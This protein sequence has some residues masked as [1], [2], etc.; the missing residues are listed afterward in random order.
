MNSQLK[1]EIPYILL[2]LV[3]VFWGFACLENL[4]DHKQI[5]LQ[6]TQVNAKTVIKEKNTIM[7]KVSHYNPQLGGVNCA[8]FVD[9]E[10]VSKMAN[11]ER[12]QEWVGLAIACPKELEFGTKLKIGERV[13]E[14]KDRGGMIKKVDNVYWVDM[15]TLEGL[16][17]YGEVVKAEI[18]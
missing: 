1:K 16:Y 14:C 6:P 4:K 5:T 9:D 3:Y 7:V 8:W 18:L 13:W 11:G 15:L 2:L 10:C 12:W 17:D